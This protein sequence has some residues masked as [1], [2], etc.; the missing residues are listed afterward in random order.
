MCRNLKTLG[1][2][3][4]PVLALSAVAAS[5]ASAAPQFLSE[6]EDTTLTGTQGLA[7]ANILTTDT[8]EMKCKV[9]KFDGTMEPA[10]TTTLTLKPTYEECK[11]AG[12][13]ALVTLNGCRYQF[14]LGENTETFEAKMDIECPDGERL[15]IDSPECSI[16][17]PPQAGLG[18]VKFTNEGEMA[19]RSII[20]DLK[21]G[22]IDY[23][24]H[25]EGCANETVTTNNGTYTG[26]ITIKGENAAEEHVGIW[27]E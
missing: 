16:T 23:V 4:L 13:N 2:T 6:I 8:G 7:M 27:V 25:G 20:A 1:L 9:V 19:T 21:I 5:A 11:L 12:E 15:V 22:G 17:I 24:E 26:Q 14:H 10:E 18:E 3:I